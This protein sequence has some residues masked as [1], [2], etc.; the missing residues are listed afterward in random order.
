[1][2]TPNQPDQPAPNGTPD[3]P[4]QSCQPSGGGIKDHPTTL[5]TAS[6]REAAIQAASAGGRQLASGEW[7]AARAVVADMT[8]EELAGQVIVARYSGTEAPLDLVEQFHLGGVIV[9]GDTFESIEDTVRS[10]QLLQEHDDRTWPLVIGVDQEGGMVNRL[11]EPMTQF[12]TGRQRA[13]RTLTA[14][15]TLQVYTQVTP[16]MDQA[17]ANTVASLILGPGVPSQTT[18]DETDIRGEEKSPL[19]SELTWAKPQVSDGSGGRI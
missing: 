1:M 4:G 3:E 6:D 15:F 9:M 12:P 18:R 2:Q 17:A 16:G 19:E 14:A 11:G 5:R 7:R 13:T 10:N 8:D